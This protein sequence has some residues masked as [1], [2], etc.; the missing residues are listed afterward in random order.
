MPIDQPPSSEHTVSNRV[1]TIGYSIRQSYRNADDATHHVLGWCLKA[2]LLLYFVFCALFLVVRYA[3]MPQIENYRVDIE[4]AASK[5]IGLPV[6]IGAITASWDGLRPHLSLKD[7][8][9][10]DRDGNQALSLP[11]VSATV[12]WK[13]LVLA[14]IRLESLQIDSPQLDIKR[15]AK[16]DF[17]IAGLPLDMKSD[18]DGKGADWVLSQHNITIVNGQLIWQDDLRQAPRLTLQH[19]DIRLR[20]HGHTHQFGLTATPPTT[21]AA[22]IDIRAKFTHP[23]F[24]EKI[25]DATRWS[26]VIYTDLRNTDLARWKPYLDFPFDLRQAKGSV[27]AWLKFD[28]ARV[29]DFTADL[30]LSDVD[31]QL[32]KDLQPLELTKVD[33]RISV[34]ETLSTQQGDGVP[35]FG[36]NGHAVALE[37]FSMQTKDGLVLPTTTLSERFVAAT[38]S[39]PEHT[40]V[41]AKQLDLQAM[42]NF[43]GRLPLSPD[44]LQMLHD[45]SPRGQ[46]KNFSAQ[47]EGRYPEVSSYRIEGQF[48][49]LALHAQAAKV[50]RPATPSAPAQAAVPAIPGFENISGSI[51]AN[52]KGGALVLGARQAKFLLPGYFIEPELDFDVMNV[53]VKWTF[54]K[55]DQLLVDV[56]K[57]NFTKQQMHG[58][59]VGT[60]LMPLNKNPNDSL[61]VVDMH[62]SITG[63]PIAEV[64]HYLPLQMNDDARRWLSDALVGGTLRDGEIRIKGDLAHFPFATIASSATTNK[65][66]EANSVT[67]NKN[68]VKQDRKKEN[69]NKP[70]GEFLFTGRIDDGSL[71]YDPGFFGRD[72]KMPLWPLLEKI[73]GTIKFDRARMEIEADSA[74]T[75]G[76][77]VSKVKAVIPNLLAENLMLNIDGQASGALQNF[78]DY[79]IDS[80]VSDWIARFT[81]ETTTSGDATLA[82]KLALPLS[83]LTD[84]KVTGVVKLDNNNVTLM[85]AMPT[86]SQANGQLEFNETGLNLNDVK[87]SF[88]GGP[89]VLSG[90]TQKNNDIIIKAAGTLTA[91]GLSK[92]FPV[93]NLKTV[94]SRISGNARYSATIA[95]RNK[96]LDIL[97]ESNLRGLGLNFPAPLNKAANLDL[98]L[99][100]TL[101]DQPAAQKDIA[102]DVVKVTVG[103]II[104]ASYQREKNTQTNAGW[105]VVRGGI[106]VNVP[107]PAPDSGVVANIDL[108]EL[109]VDDWLT[110][111]SSVS[112]TSAASSSNAKLSNTTASTNVSD[113]TQYIEPNMIAARTDKLTLLGKQLDKVVVGASHD[114]NVW[115]ANIDATQISGYVTWRESS[116]G[117]GLGKVTARLASLIVP[118]NAKED[119]KQLLQQDEADTVM[120]ALDIVAENFEL[121]GKKLGQ[122]E[123][124][125]HY[126]RA[127]SGREWSIQKLALRNADA[128]LSATGKWVAMGKHNTSNL[129]YKLEIADAGKLLN[130]FGYEDVLR[131]G[132]GNMTGDVSWQG[133]P[134][135]LDVPSLTGAIQLDI[136]DGQF[137][138]VDLGAA[139]LLGVLSLQSIP[140]RLTLD[141]RDVFSQGFAFDD[142]KG[143]ATIK[144]GVAAT[145]NFKMRGV[146][147]TVLMDG[148]ADIAKETQ[149]LHVVVIP[150]INAGAASVAYALAINPVIG[151]GTFLAQLFLREPLA[152]AFTF[153]YKVTGPWKD[154]VVTKIDRKVNQSSNAD[155]KQEAKP[156]DKL[157][158]QKEAGTP[159]VPAGK[160]STNKLPVITP[161][162]SNSRKIAE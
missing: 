94:T 123:L 54:Q 39:K 68:K 132:K 84:A 72:G 134:F 67:K 112:A 161:S 116:S 142:I 136:S 9:I 59:F 28:H 93:A 146:A 35:T 56:R 155:G 127:S 86:M 114:V 119:V 108:P 160:A 7:V 148:T 18:S 14:T 46:L 77:E 57:L 41:S 121:F 62:G 43:I 52:N 147:A 152:R 110:I 61:G 25:S 50:A 124:V 153:E 74:T 125:A 22:P 29:A 100:F 24:S 140:R 90:G 5:T 1:W 3:V 91:A 38:K 31:A 87:A 26:G 102:R 6:S 117:R 20:N 156:D 131:R 113:V 37:N 33:G 120:P 40:E 149:D 48:N 109:N 15:D 98:P 64:G 126:V 47:W 106:G 158:Q 53:D 104:S 27:R 80:P 137:L 16:G 79:T 88:L 144:D 159:L 34:R 154:P 60:H 101:S 129:V 143:L 4:Q 78:I 95:V 10:R 45:F 111:V 105:R 36:A 83:H 75:H 66:G 139:K 81:D 71:N 130:R 107:A 97:A 65:N 69:K 145:N 58:A 85:Q 44:H 21:L 76:A 96:Q 70:Q 103:N 23:Y 42:S 99:K 141:F 12:A 157:E 138:K 51:N 30:S 89:L 63:L 135:S 73:Q 17:F 32:R 150:E 115:Q 8:T 11:G 128:L 162:M 2:L 19:V 122:L 133:A 13:S 82:L 49:Q 55:N 92:S 151:V 118:D